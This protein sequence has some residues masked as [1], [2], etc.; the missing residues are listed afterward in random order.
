MNA[1]F[2]QSVSGLTSNWEHQ[3]VISDNLA[4]QGV[5]GHKQQRVG[6]ESVLSS[7]VGASV[8][9]LNNPALLHTSPTKG[10]GGFDFSQGPLQDGSSP[11]HIAI[12]GAGF[13]AVQENDGSTSFT[14]NGAFVLSPDQRVQTADG[15]DVLL[16]NGSPLTLE[17]D[18]NLVIQPDGR[19]QKDGQDVGRLRV[20]DFTSPHSDL[21]SVAHGRF[22]PNQG[23]APSEVLPGTTSVVQ[24]KLEGSN[25]KA[26]SHM[27]EMI[28]VMRAY[29]A[30]QKSLQSQDE[31]TSRLIK[32][33]GG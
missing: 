14:R 19:V 25:G 1:G 4:R 21:S 15:A 6:F 31:A 17:S 26:V 22:K 28:A 13:F 8:V 10:A 18:A 30:N 24:H 27:V 3:S 16:D 33:I 23:V 32:A 9:D 2:Y 20:V 12:N 11:L 29:E 5:A 7:Q